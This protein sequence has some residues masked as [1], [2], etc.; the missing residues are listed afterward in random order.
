MNTNLNTTRLSCAVPSTE[1]S[2]HI[3]MFLAPSEPLVSCPQSPSAVDLWNWCLNERWERL[4]SP[5][6]FL[7][8]N[9]GVTDLQRSKT[10]SEIFEIYRYLISAILGVFFLCMH[11]CV[12]CMTCTWINLSRLE[13]T[14]A[15]QNYPD[16]LCD[17]DE[18][19]RLIADVAKIIPAC[20]QHQNGLSA[21]MY[22]S[23]YFHWES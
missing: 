20:L 7:L 2:A 5:T 11:S 15:T 12:P 10:T 14:P 4:M 1:T 19:G 16:T 3:V 23:W 13:Q 6:C 17:Q 18:V 8:K 21:G 22:L 9:L